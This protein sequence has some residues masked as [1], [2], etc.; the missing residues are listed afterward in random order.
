M[1]RSLYNSVLIYPVAHIHTHNIHPLPSVITNSIY[2]TVNYHNN[3]NNNINIIRRVNKN[4]IIIWWR[5]N[6]WK[7]T[8]Y[9]YNRTARRHIQ[10][11]SLYFFVIIIIITLSSC[12]AGRSCLLRPCAGGPP[13][14]WL[15]TPTG[16]TARR[17]G[18]GWPT[19]PCGGT[20]RTHAG[21]GQTLRNRS[22][23]WNYRGP[24]PPTKNRNNRR[25]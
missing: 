6:A 12:R 20:V 10:T 1:S 13:W 9:H 3:N 5:D 8:E 24:R 25:R 14:P 7:R 2:T 16:C 17:C 23:F 22:R 15:G 11:C 4:N 21:P 18:P 19:W